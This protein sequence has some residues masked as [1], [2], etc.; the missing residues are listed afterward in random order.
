[1]IIVGIITWIVLSLFGVPLALTL[2]LLAGLFDFIPNIG[3]FIAG[4]PGVLMALTVSPTTA[5]YVLIFYFVIQ[6]L[7]SYVL[8]ACF[9][10][11]DR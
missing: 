9:A 10:A 1:M 8:N 3:P 7:E 2:G 6:S 5:L 4:I 11:E